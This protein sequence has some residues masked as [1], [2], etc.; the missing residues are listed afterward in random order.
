MLYLSQKSFLLRCELFV[1]IIPPIFSALFER[2]KGA[3]HW[4]VKTNNPAPITL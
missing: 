4:F 1:H 2:K 3:G